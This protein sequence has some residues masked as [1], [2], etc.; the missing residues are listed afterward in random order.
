MDL[1]RWRLAILAAEAGSAAHCSSRPGGIEY[2]PGPAR[3]EG[4]D[5]WATVE[6]PL[7]ER[8][9]AFWARCKHWLHKL[10]DIAK[11]LNFAPLHLH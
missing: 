1:I 11:M 5:W 3:S 8:R 10:K 9:F 6:A 7:D 2:V 4:S